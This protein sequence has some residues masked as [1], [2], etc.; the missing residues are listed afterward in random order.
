[1]PHPTP[2]SLATIRERARALGISIA[3]ERE[4]FVRAGAEHL[5]DAVQRLDRIAADDEALLESDRR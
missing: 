4:A 5:H 2:P 3:V 1:M